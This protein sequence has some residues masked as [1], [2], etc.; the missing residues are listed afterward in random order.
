MSKQS[1]QHPD[2]E[3][4]V[5]GKNKTKKNRPYRLWYYF[6]FFWRS[7]KGRGAWYKVGDYHTEDERSRVEAKWRR[8]R[9]YSDKELQFAYTQ[10]KPSAPPVVV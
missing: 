3:R 4:P 10:E 1:S 5:H 2:V 8:E 6:D 7:E 9:S